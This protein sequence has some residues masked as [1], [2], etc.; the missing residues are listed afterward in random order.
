MATSPPTA[1]SSRPRAQVD[2][3]AHRALGLDGI[4]VEDEHIQQADR[5]GHRHP[6]EQHAQEHHPRPPVLDQ[7]QI[8][9]QQLRVQRRDER[10]REELGV[11]SQSA[12]IAI[13]PTGGARQLLVQPDVLLICCNTG[14]DRV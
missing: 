3:R 11:H 10:Q 7:Q 14:H 12:S 2:A 8:N 4:G 1:S 9:G 6:T 13:V 5:Q